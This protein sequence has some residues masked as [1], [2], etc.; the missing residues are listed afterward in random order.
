MEAP[1]HDFA[2]LAIIVTDWDALYARENNL[3]S[4]IKFLHQQYTKVLMETA[5]TNCTS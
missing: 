3:P 4:H 1:P 5:I 2:S